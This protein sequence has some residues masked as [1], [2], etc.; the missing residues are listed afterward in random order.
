MRRVRSAVAV[1][2]LAVVASCTTSVAG[3]PSRAAGL[4]CSGT[5]SASITACLRTSL[6][7][8]WSRELHRTF[9]A[10]VVLDFSAASVP[11]QCRGA[12]RIGTAFTCPNDSSIYLTPRYVAAMRRAS[13]AADTWYRFAATLG[14]EMGH[15]VQFA[16]HEPLVTDQGH[17]ST[18]RS[19]EI[20]Q[21]ADC[22]SGVWAGHVGL[23]PRRFLAA[24]QADFT[25]IDSPFERRTHGNPSTRIAAIRRGLTG[26]T[27]KACGLA[28]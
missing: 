23:D 12:V 11:R 6:T 15:V 17:A 24:A 27:P 3:T 14:H 5:D 20:E 25:I 9:R 10:P 7:G 21:Q 22:L 4:D 28:H 13:P 1:L 2:L 18:A 26:G 19:Q 8:F 16:V